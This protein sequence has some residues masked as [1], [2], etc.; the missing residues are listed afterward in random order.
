MPSFANLIPQALSYEL[1][2]RSLYGDLSSPSAFVAH[3]GSSFSDASGRPKSTIYSSVSRNFSRSS[4]VT[5]QWCNKE[6]H[7]AKKCHKFN[8]LLKKAKGDGLLK[9][10]AATSIDP[11]TTSKWYT[12]I[13]ATS[14]MINDVN[15][16]DNYVPCTGP[17]NKKGDGSRSM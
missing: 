2:S 4:V 13:G 6:R 3:Q 7:T 15:A 1:F 12:D 5:Y 14:H 17:N 16:L 9:A 10:F 11:S 8:R